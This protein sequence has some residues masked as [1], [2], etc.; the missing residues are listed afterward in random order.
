MSVEGWAKC[1]GPQNPFRISGVN[2]VAGKS[3]T[4]EVHG[5]QIQPIT[6]KLNQT[7]CRVEEVLLPPR[8]EQSKGCGSVY[9]K[10]SRVNILQQLYR[11]CVYSLNST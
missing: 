9:S 4:I 2:S 7:K 3:N 10:D 11:R 5:D 1:L 6:T 8:V